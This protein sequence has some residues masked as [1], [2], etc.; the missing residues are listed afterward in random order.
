MKSGELRERFLKYFEGNGHKRLPSSSLVPANDPTLFFTNAGM[1]QFKDVFLGADKR[2]YKRATTSQKCMRVSGKH[3]DLEQVGC[4]PRHHTFFEMLGNFS[5][6]DYFKRDAIAYGWEFLTKTVGI[7]KDRLCVTI[8]NDDDEAEKLWL[9]HIGKDRIFRLGE[10]DNFWA[11]GETGPCGPCSEIHYDRK[12]SSKITKKDLAADRFMEVWNLVFMQF[13]RSAGGKMKKLAKPSIDTGMGLERLAAVVQGVEGNYE[14]DLFMPI[15]RKIEEITGKKYSE[16]YDLNTYALKHLHTDFSIRVIA[17]HIRAG[18]FL[19]GDG[20]QPSNEGRGYVLRRII[21]RAIRHGRMIGCQKNFFEPI[22]HVVIDEMGGAYPELI[23]HR[24]F[25]E[26]VLSNEEERFCATL[27]KGLEI[28]EETFA[29]IKKKGEKN[30]PGEVVFKLYDTYGFPKDLTEDIAAEHG[31]ALDGAGFE[32]CMEAQ[33]VKAR[34]AWKGSGEEK[35]D[36]IYKDL[37]AKGVKSKFVGYENETYEAKVVAVI[38]PPPAVQF[39]TDVTPF[40]G[41]S[42]GQTFDTGVAVADGLAITITGTVRPLPNLIIHKGVLESGTLKNGMVLTLAVDSDRRADIKR[43]HTA[44]HLL[45]KALRE[46][47]GEHVKQAGSYVGSD[48]LRFDFSHF[49]A[50]TGDEIKKVESD[51]N[52]IIR[53]NFKVSVNETSYGEA[54]KCGALA[55]FGEKYGEKVRMVEAGDYSREL[56][57][58]THVSFTGDIGLLKITSESSVAAGVRRIEA[59]TGRGAMEHIEKEED[60]LKAIAR[61]LAVSV[62]DAGARVSK[63][64][65][66]VKQLEKKIEKGAVGTVEVEIKESNGVKF[67]AAR[68]EAPSVV[69]L[70]SLADQYKQKIGSG[71]VVLGA[72]IEGKVSLIVMVT[73]DLTAKYN[74]GDI[75]KKLAVQVGGTGGGRPEMAQGGGPEV[76]KLD[77]ILSQTGNSILSF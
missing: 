16:K 52:D 39:I 7:P 60:E 23:Q 57:G 58:G 40:Y 3:N 38:A 75:V 22:V 77:F 51:V 6:G 66:H 54:V 41:E 34:A 48:R 64:L 46:A 72:V 25:I 26:K 2:P 61:S 19:I 14:T 45:H 50:M 47:L 32:K 28:L 20:V 18:T 53:K 49:Q 31:L 4:T 5:F 44:T 55:F 13:E 76:T 36:S 56:C 9:K 8:F 74:A 11:M 59:V 62:F 69:A 70:R 73:K 27:D 37:A 63:L 35:V 42:G 30:V 17:D 65:E 1:V 43:N 21:R 33:R 12:P 10:D 68:V 24:A 29:G 71:V 67:I 15:I